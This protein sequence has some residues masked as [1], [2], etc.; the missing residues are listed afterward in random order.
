[1]AKLE[2]EIA[3]K[4]TIWFYIVKILSLLKLT[5]VIK[6]IANKKIVNIYMNGKKHSGIRIIEIM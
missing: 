1:M 3:Y 6:I 5:D 4:L 2:I